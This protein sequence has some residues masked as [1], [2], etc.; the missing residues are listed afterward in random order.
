MIGRVVRD[1]YV[2]DDGDGSGAQSVTLTMDDGRRYTLVGWG[3]D[4]WGIHLEVGP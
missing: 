4:Y 1:I 3:H 2:N